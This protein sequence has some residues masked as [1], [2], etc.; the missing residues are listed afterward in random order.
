MKIE[1]RLKV[2]GDR[3]GS[4]YK[5][6]TVAHR[7]GQKFAR[8]RCVKT[9]SIERVVRGDTVTVLSEQTYAA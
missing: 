2:E 1:Y 9:Y 8:A 4:I 6:K 5:A 3:F 7:D